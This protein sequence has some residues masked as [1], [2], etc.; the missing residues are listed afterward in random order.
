M[1]NRSDKKV[2]EQFLKTL[3]LQRLP[4][5]MR[6][7]LSVFLSFPYKF[8]NC[9]TNLAIAKGQDLVLEPSFPPV[10]HGNILVGHGQNVH[11]SDDYTKDYGVIRE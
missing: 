5:N 2:S 3:W 8:Q 7:T 1:C 10:G 9:I 11:P 6:G 4:F